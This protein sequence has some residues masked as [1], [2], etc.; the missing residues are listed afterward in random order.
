MRN[1][2]S[3]TAPAAGLLLLSLLLTLAWNA[4]AQTNTPA[5]ANAPAQTNDATGELRALVVNVNTKLKQGKRSAADLAEDFRAFDE[6]LAKHKG[7]KTDAVGNIQ[8]SKALLYLQVLNDTV[9]GRQAILQLKRDYP[10]TVAGQQADLM[11][12]EID[13]TENAQK[14]RASLTNGVPAPAFEVKGVD[15]QT[16]SLAGQH[17]K[18]VLLDFWATWCKLCVIE[19]PFLKLMYVKYH[20]QGFEII[21]ISV[22]KD[23]Q[24]LK[25]FVKQKE[26][27]WPQYFDGG[28]ATN[29]VSLQYG[30]QPLP[31]NFLI[32]GE[33][34]IIGRDLHGP[35]LDKAIAAALPKK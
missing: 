19:A 22:D 13:F 21:G 15:G 17:G 32:N 12:A 31:C 20:D 11:L 7:E 29:R 26:L 33:G 28:E 5:Q 18:L 35:S 34:K 1:T 14:T 23:A 24:Q 3:K 8:Y 30:V 6:L 9:N 2:C 27:P 4:P 25:D 10:Q 16:I